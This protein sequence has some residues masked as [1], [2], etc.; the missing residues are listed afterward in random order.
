[1]GGGGVSFL[2]WKTA[3]KVKS[4]LIERPLE[5]HLNLEIDCTGVYMMIYFTCRMSSMMKRDSIVLTNISVYF[6]WLCHCFHTQSEMVNY[7]LYCFPFLNLLV[8]S[9]LV[10]NYLP[11][12]PNHWVMCSLTFYI[13]LENTKKS[14]LP[15]WPFWIIYLASSKALH[16]CYFHRRWNLLTVKYLKPVKET[17]PT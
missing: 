13:Q 5:H 15:W 17:W 3:S 1:M 10:C 12:N 11:W 9:K 7:G 2:L 8:L 6:S 4:W 16:L 14:V